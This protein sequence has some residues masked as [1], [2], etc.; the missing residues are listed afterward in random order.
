MH[1]GL[2]IVSQ[3]RRH[4][5]LAQKRPLGVVQKPPPRVS[6]ISPLGPRPDLTNT[7]SPEPQQAAAHPYKV[8]GASEAV[9]GGAGNI[10]CKN[11]R[12]DSV[13]FTV[14]A[15]QILPIQTN[16][17]LSTGTTATALVGLV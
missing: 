8:Q 11:A 17:V 15:G 7:K 12:G 6:R 1:G 4:R 14:V 2:V 16:Q 13:T 3:G 9:Q 10:V 5:A